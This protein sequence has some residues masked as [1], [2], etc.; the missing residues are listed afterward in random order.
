[1]ATR[2][3]ALLKAEAPPSDV[4]DRVDERSFKVLVEA[5]DRALAPLFPSFYAMA[6][7]WPPTMRPERA[8]RA[9]LLMLL[10][11]C[12]SAQALVPRVGDD[13]RFGPYLRLP[14]SESLDAALLADAL[15]RLAKN[16][17]VR[18]AVAS[19]VR[20]L[21]AGGWTPTNEAQLAAWVPDGS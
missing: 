14:P 21:Q 17:N 9:L 4:S 16:I 11:G 15:A 12:D 1:M 10:A 19:V 5:T 18:G 7:Q 2:A 8:T 3:L 20:E 13:P 6:S